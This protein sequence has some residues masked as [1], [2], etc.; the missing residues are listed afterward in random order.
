MTC[1][2][3]RRTLKLASYGPDRD[4][5]V[6]QTAVEKPDTLIGEVSLRFIPRGVFSIER[7]IDSPIHS[8][9]ATHAETLRLRVSRVVH[10]NL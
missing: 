4:G 3:C 5:I 2:R 1:A 9:P 7:L 10:S 6:S 8:V